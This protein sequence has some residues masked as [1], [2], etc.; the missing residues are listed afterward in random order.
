VARPTEERKGLKVATLQESDVFVVGS[1]PVADTAEALKLFAGTLGDRVFALPDGETGERRMWI[2]GLGPLTYSQV[3][4][5]EP[6]PGTEAPFGAYR[7]KE[8]VER[9]SLKGYLPYADAALDSYRTFVEMR[10]AGTIADDLL[11]Q[12]A[13]PTPRAAV[14]IYFP[15]VE[16]WKP[17]E[18]AYVEAIVADIER[19]LAGIPASDLAIQWDYA[20]E[21]VDMEGA[22]SGRREMDELM[23]W[24]PVNSAEEKF[25]DFTSAAYLAPLTEVIPDD[26]I[27]GYHL[28]LGAYPQA[29]MSPAEDLSLVVRVANEMVA[30]TPRKIDFVHLPGTKYADESYFAPLKDLQVGDARIFIGIECGDGREELERRAAA[31]QKFLPSFG[32]SHHCGYGRD[33]EGKVPELLGDLLAV[34]EELS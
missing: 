13:F 5:L 8:G 14:S 6:D 1:V 7:A 26:V 21:L 19:I 2:G 30:N 22:E 31:A 17:M 16:E 9:V 34:A 24:N 33:A 28:C 27:C 29:P 11:F 25:A 3:P 15:N 18:A 4:D 10:E 20:S 12:V 32:I 23:P